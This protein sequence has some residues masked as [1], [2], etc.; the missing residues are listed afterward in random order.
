M[1]RHDSFHIYASI[2]ILFWS[3]PYMLTK[4]ALPY[5]SPFTLAFLRYAVASLVLIPF[6][7]IAK[8][9]LPKL[10]DIPWFFAAGGAGFFV[11]MIVFNTGTGLVTAATGSIVLTCVPVITAV[12]ARVFY[13]EKL[14]AYQWAAVGVEFAGIVVL[15][16]IGD[17]FSINVGVLWLTL[18]SFLLSSYNLLQ[19]KLSR[20]YTPL[21]TSIYSIFAGTLL[22]CV[23]SPAAIR[24]LMAAPAITYVYIG[25]MG[26]LSSAVAYVTWTIAL[27]KAEKTSYVS[28]YMFIIPFLTTIWGV[29][30][31]HEVPGWSTILGGVIILSGVLLF[32]KENFVRGSAKA[33]SPVM[34]DL[35]VQK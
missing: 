16:L 26:V 31:G 2:T 30:L 10:K 19:R 24:Q 35:P 3:L 7:L 14:R 23:F 17:S 20:T 6:A 34:E 25:I 18:G 11:Y 1:K 5:F 9:K 12:L 33:K 32:Y 27:A 4:L 28:N 21:Q 22:L 29:V 13:K 8:V 15:L